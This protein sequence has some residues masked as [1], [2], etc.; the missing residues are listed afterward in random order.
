MVLV[1]LQIRKTGICRTHPRCDW[2]EYEQEFATIDCLGQCLF[3]L[4]LVLMFRFGPML[5]S[6]LRRLDM[7]VP[8]NEVGT[9]SRQR[10][11]VGAGLDEDILRNGVIWLQV[12]I[13]N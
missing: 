12:S 5:T 11:S 4:H 1:K 13:L 2:L 9:L 8:W 3:G 7:T 10:V 6:G